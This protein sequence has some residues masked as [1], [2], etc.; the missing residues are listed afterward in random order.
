MDIVNWKL[1]GHPLN[2]FTVVL[3]VIIAGTFGHLVL[4]YFGFEPA[5]SKTSSY[6]E[7]PAGQSPRTSQQIAAVS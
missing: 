7:L 5:T 6:T 3:M 4:T 1:L 2:W